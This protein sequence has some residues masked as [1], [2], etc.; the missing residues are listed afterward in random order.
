MLAAA[1]PAPF[2]LSI[3]VVGF[4]LSAPLAGAGGGFGRF[5]G[6]GFLF[7]FSGTGLL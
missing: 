1:W 2:R 6:R 3:I 5:A 7:P 4:V